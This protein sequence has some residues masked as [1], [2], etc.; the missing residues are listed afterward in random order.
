MNLDNRKY[1]IL[2]FVFFIGVLYFLRLLHMQILDVSW[3][4]RAQQISEKRK[5]IIP[6]RGVIFDRNNNKIVSNTTYYNLMFVEENITEF[7]TLSFAK[8][9]HLD[10]SEISLRF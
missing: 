9:L 5:E 7:D 3:K 1:I 6:P 10:P 2:F 4:L 8:L